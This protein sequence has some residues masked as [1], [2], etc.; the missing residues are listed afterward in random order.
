MTTKRTRRPRGDGSIQ[1]LPN[2]KYKVQITVG[3]D[4]QGRQRKKS[5]TGSTQREVINHC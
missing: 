2:G 5:F 1:E 4:E 3:Y